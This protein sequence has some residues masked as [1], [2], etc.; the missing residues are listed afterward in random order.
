MEVEQEYD[1]VADLIPQLRAQQAQTTN[2]GLHSVAEMMRCAKSGT[3][4]LR[5]KLKQRIAYL[6]S[7][8]DLDIQG[9]RKHRFATVKITFSNGKEKELTVGKLY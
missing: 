6:I 5:S 7:R 2:G 9:K 3:V 4:E 8:I 1:Q